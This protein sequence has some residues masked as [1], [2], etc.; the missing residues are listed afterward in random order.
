MEADAEEDMAANIVET[1]GCRPLEKML[2][3]R[4]VDGLDGQQWRKRCTSSGSVLR[5]VCEDSHGQRGNLSDTK[6]AATCGGASS[7]VLE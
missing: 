1:L 6:G 3:H 2:R 5:R 4:V 7:V